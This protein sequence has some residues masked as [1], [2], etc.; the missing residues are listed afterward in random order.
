MLVIL[1]PESWIDARSSTLRPLT[2]TA[3][4]NCISLLESE[5]GRL[6]FGVPAGPTAAKSGPEVAPVN[7]SAKQAKAAGLMTTG[8]FGQRSTISSASAALQSSLVSRLQ[9]RTATL[10][11]T[12]FK[13]TWKVQIT[14][15]GRS[16]PLLRASAPR[17]SVTVNG[18]W[19]T[20]TTRDWKDG[21]ECPNVPINSLLGR[22][23]WLNSWPTPQ[24]SD[25]SG[26]GQAAR[27]MGET[28][29]G[30]NLN[31]FVMLA[32]WG[33][34]LTNHANGEPEAFLERKRQSMARGS[35]SMGVCLSDLNMQVKAYL[36]GWNT[37]AASDGNGG[38]RPHPDTT[39]TGQH[40]SGRKV[41]MGLASQVHIGFLNTGPARLTASG[42]MLTGLDAGM[43]SSGQLNPAHSRWLMGLP[44]E[45]DD[46][47]PTATQL[48]CRRRKPS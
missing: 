43:E 8:T 31:D 40:P 24:T 6:R 4:R 29:H 12:L 11:S 30:S 16:L 18:S 15:A 36:T 14:P 37:P 2:S 23:V 32:S 22:T 34:P 13:L 25:G 7:L 45:W 33:T 10:G 47:A 35:A 3:L 20:P 17:T 27:A 39:M 28:K 46:C 21:A 48:S 1:L 5:S 26:G 9:A 44:K 19:P 38:K 41:N 42:Q